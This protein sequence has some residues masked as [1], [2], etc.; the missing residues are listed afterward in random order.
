MTLTDKDIAGMNLNAD[1]TSALLSKLKAFKASSKNN[2][3]KF[4]EITLPHDRDLSGDFYVVMSRYYSD[5]STDER[6]FL[7]E[8]LEEGWPEDRL[9]A[10]L[11]MT[12]NEMKNAA[13]SAQSKV[14]ATSAQIAPK[15]KSS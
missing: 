5:L 1:P 4:R 2:R 9:I 10:F 3:T 14:H 8:R 7:I 11:G 13:G 12:Y 6:S 15:L